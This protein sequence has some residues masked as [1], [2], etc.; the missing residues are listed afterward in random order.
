MEKPTKYHST[1]RTPLTMEPLFLSAKKDVNSHRN[2]LEEKTILIKKEAY[3]ED[4]ASE[5]PIADLLRNPNEYDDH[6]TQEREETT[7][8]LCNLP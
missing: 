5:Y 1:S 2:G 7:F 4:M 8:P 6:S 3:C